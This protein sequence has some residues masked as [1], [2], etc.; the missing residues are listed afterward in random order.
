MF[1]CVFGRIA[2]YLYR[3]YSSIYVK[4]LQTHTRQKIVLGNQPFVMPQ[5]DS[6][7]LLHS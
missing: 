2:M 7:H 3:L 6:V 4:L 1:V 5:T